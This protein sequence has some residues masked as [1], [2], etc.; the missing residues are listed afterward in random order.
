MIPIGSREK[1]LPVVSSS[2]A[3]VLTLAC[4]AGCSQKKEPPR[5]VESPKGFTMIR[6]CAIVD[7]DTGRKLEALPDQRIT[8]EGYIGKT[9]ANAELMQII[10]QAADAKRVLHLGGIRHDSFGGKREG[11]GRADSSTSIGHIRVNSLKPGQTAE[12]YH[13]RV[14][15]VGGGFFRPWN[16]SDQVALSLTY[17]G[18]AEIVDH[19]PFG[20]SDSESRAGLTGSI[21]FD[22][23]LPHEASLIC[24]GRIGEIR[25]RDYDC[26]LVWQTTRSPD[27]L[28]DQ[29]RTI[30]EKSGQIV[31]A[32]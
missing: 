28:F 9:A 30:R 19:D 31:P 4:T 16:R 24:F 32:E 7:E 27:E 17:R 20:S 22:G 11:I 26:V 29:L 25:G 12:Q 13:V 10:E 6:W 2:L 14:S 1:R 5:F 3:V 18:T 23:E 21:E 15:W 8:A